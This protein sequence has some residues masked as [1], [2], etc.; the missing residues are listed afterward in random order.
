MLVSGKS[1]HGILQVVRAVLRTIDEHSMP[2]N[3]LLDPGSDTTFVKSDLAKNLGLEGHER[4]IK[5][6]TVCSEPK[7]TKSKSNQNESLVSH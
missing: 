7:V 3:V 5:L 1:S 2:V 6:E 4:S